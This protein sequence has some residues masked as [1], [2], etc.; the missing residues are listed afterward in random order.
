MIIKHSPAPTL[1]FPHEEEPPHHEVQMKMAKTLCIVHRSLSKPL[2]HQVISHM[3][4]LQAVDVSC[5]LSRAN[6]RDLYL[7]LAHHSRAK[8]IRVHHQAV[9][10]WKAIRNSAK[11]R[12]NIRIVPVS[13]FMKPIT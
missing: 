10:K 1:I 2:S 12:K 11:G 13:L 5:L 4:N 9:K 8:E 6:A 3:P 7:Y